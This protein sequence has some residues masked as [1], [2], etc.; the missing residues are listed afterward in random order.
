MPNHRPSNRC[1]CATCRLTRAMSGCTTPHSCF[2]RARELLNVL[3]D[4]WNPGKAQ[5]EDY[6]EAP[7]EIGTPEDDE[8]MFDP[9]ITTHGT[10]ADTFR[11]FT[12]ESPR[13]LRPKAPDTKHTAAPDT[14]AVTASVMMIQGTVRYASQPRSGDRTMSAS[15]QNPK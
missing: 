6:E 3:H 11:I 4:K 1:R 7:T 14:A 13:N 8:T 15:P 2:C 10:I 9:R 5:P 12:R